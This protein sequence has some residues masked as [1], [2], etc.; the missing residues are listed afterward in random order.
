MSAPALLAIDSSTESLCVGAARGAQQAMCV[1][2]G[3]AQA[4]ARLMADVRAVLEELHL[5]MPSLAAIAF[6]RGPGA[7]TGLRTA[8]SVAQGLAF[9]LGCPVLPVDS[10]LILA[11][12]ARGEASAPA[13]AWHD[14]A[15]VNDARMGEV[16]AG[17]WSWADDGWQV[18]EPVALWRPGP[19]DHAWQDAGITAWVGTGIDALPA[20]ASRPVHRVADRARA[21]ALLRLAQRAWVQGEAVNASQA[22]PAYVR[23]KVAL[24][25]QERQQAAGMRTASE[26]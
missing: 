4:S 17:R 1:G 24:T 14:V 23:D 3:G 16:Y 21:Q 15:V 20:S 5:S 7:F 26:V 9:G 13:A 11:E 12:A 8:C 2:E 19:L 6:G 22:L 25:T 18:I 10:L